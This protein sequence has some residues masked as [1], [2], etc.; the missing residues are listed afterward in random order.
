MRRRFTP[1]LVVAMIALAVALS[2]SAMAAGLVTTTQ[3]KDGTIRLIDLH[4]GAKSA[5]QGQR[6]PAGPQ[7]TTGAQG[8][9]GAAGARGATGPQGPQGVQGLQGVRGPEGPKGEKGNPALNAPG[10]FGPYHYVGHDDGGCDSGQET[11]A[12]DAADRWFR[13]VAAQD[14]SGYYVTRYDA[15]GSYV[16]I[17]GKHFATGGPCGTGTYTSA[18]KGTFN[19]VWTQKIT[20]AYDY[21]PD[22]T[23]S[24]DPT[25][26]E[27]LDKVFHGGTLTHVSYE[28]DYYNS[29]GDH[30]RDSSNGAILVGEIGDCPTT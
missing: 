17:A 20:G 25:W 5:L 28:F 26:D 15:N 4:P 23:L 22:A 12:K 21:N 27:F 29:C 6:A 30:W 8:P 13:V 2:G 10:D 7:G 19:G 9:Q 24:A 16:T 14:G 3:I 1:G 18:Q 11:W